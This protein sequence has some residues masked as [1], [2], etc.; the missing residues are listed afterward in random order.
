MKKTDSLEFVH[1]NLY[2]TAMDVL[3]KWV[4]DNRNRPV[5]QFANHEGNGDIVATDNHRAI[6]IKGIH[7]FKEDYLIDPKSFT[8]AK[9]NYPSLHNQLDIEKHTESIVLSRQHIALWLQILRSLNQTLRIMKD[10]LGTATMHFKEDGVEIEL[11]KYQIF[12]KPP[13]DVYQKPDFP[14][15]RFRIEY[16]RDAFEAHSR[17]ES[18]Q[19]TIYLRSANALITL[20]D[21]EAVRT[22]VMPVR[23]TEE[24]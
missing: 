9:G 5:L 24:N 7:G 6:R 13:H 4:S 11:D 1:G 2:S 16:L 19:L 20:D 14:S 21:D 22:V 17:M 3:K 15:V 18:E 23:T 12:V 10:R 8:F